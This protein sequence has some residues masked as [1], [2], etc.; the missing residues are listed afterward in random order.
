MPNESITAGNAQFPRDHCPDDQSLCDWEMNEPGF[1]VGGVWLAYAVSI[2]SDAVTQNTSSEDFM[3]IVE[4]S[5]Q[6]FSGVHS[7][8]ISVPAYLY[9]LS[10]Q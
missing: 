6:I 2:T 10:R 4:S 8:F 7:M 3:V 9:S 5:D 1:Q